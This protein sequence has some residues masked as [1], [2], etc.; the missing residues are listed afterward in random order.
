MAAR[1]RGAGRRGRAVAVLPIRL[2]RML[3]TLVFTWLQGAGF[4]VELHVHAL[5]RLPEDVTGTWLEVGCG[6]G[7]WSRLAA[8]RGFHARGIDPNRTSIWVAR[9]LSRL[10]RRRALFAVGRLESVGGG[11]ATVVAASSLLAVLPDRREGLLA[12]WDRVEPGGYLVVVEPTARLTRANAAALLARGTLPPKRRHGLRLWAAAREGRTVQ[13]S[14]FEPLKDY[15][16]ECSEELDG[17]VEV[18]IFRKPGAHSIE[19]VHR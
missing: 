6:P 15:L 7:L 17:M 19:A 16:Q 14:E 5:S 12:L 13:A 9:L 8:R 11:R 3:S 18:R 1:R 4:Y 2:S 10:C